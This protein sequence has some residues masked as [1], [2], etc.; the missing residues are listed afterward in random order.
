MR[1]ATVALLVIAGLS[2]AQ[3]PQTFTGTVSDDMCA[4]G[5]HSQMRMGSTDA[6]CTNACV[7]GHGAAYVLF[8]G[9]NVYTLTGRQTLD[10]FAGR[11]ARVVGTLD[12][13]TRTILVE[14]ITLQN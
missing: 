5:D 8:D 14:S 13:K 9:K 10:P 3:G 2:A 11:K 7:S 1:T 4:R 6:E 12:A